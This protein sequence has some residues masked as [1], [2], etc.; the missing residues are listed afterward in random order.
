MKSL[1]RSQ[2]R[3]QARLATALLLGST[4]CQ[5]V[6]W[7]GYAVNVVRPGGDRPCTLFQLVGV[8]QADPLVPGSPWFSV[9][10]TTPEYKEMIATLLAAKFSGS[11][12][13]IST[14]GTVASACGGYASVSA[15][16]VN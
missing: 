3:R 6:D 5:A 14:S 7:N 2:F 10:N 13:N 11:T 8:T 4:L 16:T 9:P 12:L 15:L 1:P